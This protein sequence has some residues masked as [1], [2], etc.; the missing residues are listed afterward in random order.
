LSAVAP[1]DRGYLR[2]RGGLIHYRRTP[3]VGA[4]GPLVMAHGGPGSSLGLVPLIGALGLD[5]TVVAPD[6]MGNGDSDPPPESETTIG[7]YADCLL[8]VMD[9]LGLETV[10]LYGHHTGAQVVCELAIAK[11]GR[12]R[13]VILDGVA[14]FDQA[15]RA[16]FLDRYAPPIVPDA[17]GAHLAWLWDFIAQTTQHFPHYLRDD[18]HRIPGG[19]AP[20]PP[21]LTD[22]VA[23]VLK[24]W[25]TYHLAYRAAFAHDMAA[26]LPLLGSPVL[27]LAVE[28]DPLSAYA[29][30]AVAL[31]PNARLGRTRRDDRAETIAAFLNEES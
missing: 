25:S 5:R 11:S 13:R 3:G 29:E 23:E 10:D 14:L 1:I 27:V 31:A 12:V 22:R 24:V 7:F 17:G 19:R 6:M 18:A 16:E 21:L 2:A 28:G 20:P 15:L 30:R 9:D 8:A 4:A 26:R